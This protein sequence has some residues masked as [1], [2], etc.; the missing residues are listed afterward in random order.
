MGTI[1][2]RSYARSTALRLT[3]SGRR[4]LA[5]QHAALHSHTRRPGLVHVDVETVVESGGIPI[6]T[7]VVGP[8]AAEATVVFIHGFTLAAEVFYMQVDYL[9]AHFP[10]VKSLLI[11]ARGHGRT[12]RVAPES[13]TIDGT[14]DD[15]LAAITTHAPEGPL[16]L[17]GHSLGGLTALNLV[18]R[19]D[20]ELRERIAGVILAATSIESLSAQGLP[21]ILASPIAEKVRDVTEAS[22]DDAEAFRHYASQF[23][24]PALSTAVFKR[25]INDQVVEFHAAMIHETPLDTFVGFFDDLQDHDEL[26][27]AGAMAGIS[28]YVLAGENDD[29]TPLSQSE[30]ICELWPEARC[31]IAEGAGHMLPLE[32][33]GILNNNIHNLLRTVLE[34]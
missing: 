26:D 25:P 27:A 16:I 22:P 23:I 24:A 8:P 6:Q 13:C 2:L 4:R 30:R 17:V 32:A 14:A 15:V 12:G 9:R 21:Q 19:A 29:V 7:Y 34:G 33:P 3:Q 5:L 31:Q 11:D 28:G 1:R 18:K 10:H 20:P